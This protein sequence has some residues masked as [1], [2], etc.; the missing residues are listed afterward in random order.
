MRTQHIK[1]KYVN[2]VDKTHTTFLYVKE[3]IHI[4]IQ[5]IGK[6]ETIYTYNVLI[7]TD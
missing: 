7:H 6:H 4:D 3:I 5:L 1:N 2:Y